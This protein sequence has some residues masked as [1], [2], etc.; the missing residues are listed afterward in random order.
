MAE[1]EEDTPFEASWGFAYFALA[2]ETF[3]RHQR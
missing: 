2:R 1:L 3:S